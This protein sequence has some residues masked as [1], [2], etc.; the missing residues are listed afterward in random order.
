MHSKQK[1]YK[2]WRLYPNKWPQ[3]FKKQIWSTFSSKLD[4]S[5]LIAMKLE[6][7]EWC[8][9]L[10]VYSKFHF[11]FSK[12][13]EKI[14]ENFTHSKMGKIIA[15]IPQIRLVRKMKKKLEKVQRTTYVPNLICEAMTT[16]NEFDLL[17]AVK[18]G[19]C[20][21]LIQ[22]FFIQAYKKEANLWY[23]RGIQ[24]LHLPTEIQFGGICAIGKWEITASVR[25]PPIHS[26]SPG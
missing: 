26:T 12:H 22:L 21:G 13:V 1:L 5:V 6:F 4:Q 11:D 24:D 14:L 10:D 9:L 15:Q 16:G 3:E 2:I 20:H 18:Y 8:R 25:P 23:G 7:D 17:S 19:Y